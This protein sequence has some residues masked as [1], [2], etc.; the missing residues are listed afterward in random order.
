MGFDLSLILG[1]YHVRVGMQ[2]LT[3]RTLVHWL[4]MNTIICQQAVVHGINNLEST[5]GINMAECLDLCAWVI[6]LENDYEKTRSMIL[7]TPKLEQLLQQH[8][9]YRN[10]CVQHPAMSNFFDHQV[11]RFAKLPMLLTVVAVGIMMILWCRIKTVVR[12]F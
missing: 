3:L 11:L 7:T 6:H 12:A 5:S 4:M 1:W 10:G 8:C 9:M 2:T